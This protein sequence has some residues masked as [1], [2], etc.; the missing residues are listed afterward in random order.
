[1]RINKYLALCGLG[2]RRKVEDLVINNRV[3]VNGRL[4]VNL[5]TDIKE[6]SDIVEVDDVVVKTR[7]EYSYYM[8]NKPK[9]YVTTMSDEFGRKTV[10]DLIADIPERVFP[11]GRLD[12][13]TEGLLLFTNDGELSQRLTSPSS[14]IEKTYYCTIEGDIKESELAV[15]RA[16]VV[17]NGKR[18]N[19]CKVNVLEKNDNKT[20]LKIVI[21][22]G[23]NRQIRRMLEYIGKNITFLKRVSIANLSLGGLTRGTYRKLK[24]D[25]IDYLVDLCGLNQ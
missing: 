3:K 8:L 2:A 19:K 7:T 10:M 20:K 11:V 12:Y 22:E 14:E 25:E 21:N 13:D 5:A 16:G 15:L 17:I 23:K 1:M 6:G 18:L 9:G 24:L 4:V